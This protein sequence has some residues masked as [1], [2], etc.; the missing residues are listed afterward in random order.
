MN[1][2]EKSKIISLWESGMS[3]A[4]IKRMTAVSPREFDL[5]VKE[6]KVKGEFPK[7]HKT[8]EDKIVEAY[9]R[10]ERNPYKIAE[11]YGTTIGNVRYALRKNKLYLGKKTRVW[12]HCDR[13]NAIIEDLQDGEL[14]QVEIAR[15]HQVSRQ[16]ITNVKRK[17]EK[18]G[19]I[20]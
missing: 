14:S 8:C 7:T 12:V 20:K 10:G 16:Y 13:T 9:H 4:Q 18:W 2:S 3:L 17:L 19:E 6:M 5:A 15:K 11:D 1:E